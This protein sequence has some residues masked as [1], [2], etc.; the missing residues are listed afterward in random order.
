MLPNLPTHPSHRSFGQLSQ[1]N[2]G[3]IVQLSE[4]ASTKQAAQGSRIGVEIEQMCNATPTN[5]LQRLELLKSKNSAASIEPDEAAAILRYVRK[6]HAILLP[7]EKIHSSKTL[8]NL[9]GELVCEHRGF[10]SAGKTSRDLA[11]FFNSFQNKLTDIDISIN[12]LFIYAFGSGVMNRDACYEGLVGYALCQEF[13]SDKTAIFHSGS[14]IHGK[15]PLEIR[16]QV[17]SV[18]QYA[19]FEHNGEL[20]KKGADFLEEISKNLVSM[21]YKLGSS[22]DL[23]AV[24]EQTLET[25]EQ[26]KSVLKQQITQRI[27][28]L[29]EDARCLYEVAVKCEKT[30]QSFTGFW[31]K[32]LE[33]DEVMPLAVVSDRSS[34]SNIFSFQLSSYHIL[35]EICKAANFSGN[36]VDLV[37]PEICL[38]V[39]NDK[40]HTEHLI[41]KN[42][43]ISS[44]LDVRVKKNL[45]MVHNNSAGPAIALIHDLYFHLLL[46]NQIS[47]ATRRFVLHDLPSYM[48][49]IRENTPEENR[50]IKPHL[51]ELAKDFADINYYHVGKFLTEIDQSVYILKM[52]LNDAENRLGG[53][54][55]INANSIILRPETV[56]CFMRQE[57]TDMAFFKSVMDA[58]FHRSV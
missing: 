17:G 28:S 48:D 33:S 58:A 49:F 13:S 53:P 11:D 55:F 6:N 30:Y 27:L 42:S 52:R 16:A 22:D 34:D 19:L 57:S 9:M 21:N 29:P 44:Y 54:R 40:T 10:L 2:A 37:R 45:V 26:R 8:Q 47:P 24:K 3:S 51:K 7:Q 4:E 50:E 25:Q 38:G 43:H 39:V 35:M 1:N 56:S 18:M 41:E 23:S 15:K 12:D 32:L 5:F 36:E 46:E 31:Q 20:S 14:I